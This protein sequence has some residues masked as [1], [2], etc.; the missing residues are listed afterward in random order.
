M[1]P[2]L[3]NSSVAFQWRIT[4]S[5]PDTDAPALGEPKLHVSRDGFEISGSPFAMRSASSRPNYF[6]G[7]IF[8]YTLTDLLCAGNYTYEID[9]RDA[10]G[11]SNAT[12][13][14]PGPI[15]E[16][17]NLPPTLFSPSVTPLVDQ[18]GAS[19]TYRVAYADT[20]N[21]TPTYVRMFVDRGGVAVGSQDLNFTTWVGPPNFVT[22]AWFRATMRLDQPGFNYTFRFRAADANGTVETEDIFGPYVLVPPPHVLTVA[23][24]DQAP[25]VVD[26][27]QRMVPFLNVYLTTA[28]P[29]VDVTGIRVDRIGSSTDG[30]V[31]RILLYT[32]VAGNLTLLGSRPPFG[33][34]HSAV[35]PVDLRVLQ[36]QSLP[37]YFFIDVSPAAVAE[38]TIGL[39]LKNESYI[40]VGP[41][42][43]V[44]SFF[45]YKSTRALVNGP[46]AATNLAV[47]GFAGASPGI[48]HIVGANPAL[49]WRF[50]DPNAADLAGTKFNVSVS[51]VSPPTVPW[52]RNESGSLVSVPYTGPP[53]VVGA[54]YVLQVSVFDGRLWSA[55]S[56]TLFRVN[57]PPP[58]ATPFFP[59]N[60]ASDV[61]PTT[62]VL[63]NPVADI[64]GDLVTY[65]YWVSSDVGFANPISATTVSPGS[66]ALQLATGT[67]YYWKVA[68]S[69]GW[70][71]GGNSTVW[72]FTTASGTVA[73]GTIVGRVLNG[74]APLPDA[75]VQILVNSVV[76]AG[77]TTIANGT[78]RFANLDFVS[79]TVRVGAFGFKMK[80]LAAAPTR[81]N[82]VYDMGDIVLIPEVHDG[83][84]PFGGNSTGT[85]PAWAVVLIPVLLAMTIATS[86]FGLII[87]VRRRR[88]EPDDA[89][90]PEAEAGLAVEPP[91][92]PAQVSEPKR[93]PV[94]EASPP[95]PQQKSLAA[96]ARS[97]P[98]T[99]SVPAK[100]PA[101]AET[102]GMS[103]APPPKGSQTLE[104]YECPECGRF[105]SAD[106]KKCEC[107]AI[108][109]S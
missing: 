76:V 22:G 74:T 53:L 88:R 80:V 14:E 58:I 87:A 47:N 79:Y 43:L 45:A 48:L 23:G 106:A 66:P 78:F 97:S 65:W 71:V 73:R 11:L 8:L 54:S 39:E 15:V 100:K 69:D 33:A 82:P 36:G 35:F 95:L 92:K 56:T 101:P 55:P 57:T 99:S 20:E 5:D 44:Q 94:K 41:G 6:A 62:N 27:G 68:A 98:T 9:V 29:D 75:L 4:Y 21:E 59:A 7:A 26:Q 52:F 12:P 49:S 89:D 51:R 77:N 18:A 86:L 31:S 104:V 40:T 13:V 60:Q 107:G 50:T 16:C 17:P 1:D 28:S 42:D 67:T 102:R 32:V 19:F 34:N 81:S 93:G 108:F 70:Q 85:L 103:A 84:G 63:W 64:E 83:G 96:G 46:P 2:D 3:G 61:S 91:G 38:D 25:L 72:Q 24:L 30:E 37:L 10:R 109:E 90:E 105:V